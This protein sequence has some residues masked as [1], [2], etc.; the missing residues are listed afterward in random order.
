MNIKRYFFEHEL[1]QITHELF[2]NEYI[3]EKFMDNLWIFV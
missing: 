2:V 3:H 1:S